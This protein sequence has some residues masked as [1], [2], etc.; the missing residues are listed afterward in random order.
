MAAWLNLALSLPTA[1]EKVSL[2][3]TT[4]VI[5]H[6]CNRIGKPGQRGGVH[7]GRLSS[8]PGYVSL[9]R[10]SSLSPIMHCISQRKALLLYPNLYS[11][12]SIM[13][14]S[15]DPRHIQSYCSTVWGRG[16]YDVDFETDDWDKFY[17]TIKRHYGTSLGPPLTMTSVCDSEQQARVELH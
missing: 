6:A 5:Q 12:Y 10:T 3:L 9:D 16:D 11:F 2:F 14:A 1:D 4:F 13:M 7:F 15:L 17:I 8:H